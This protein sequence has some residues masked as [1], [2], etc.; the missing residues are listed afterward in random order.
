MKNGALR[1]PRNDNKLM[2]RK[3]SNGNAK[4]YSVGSTSTLKPG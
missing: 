1:R 2:R 3:N 4:H